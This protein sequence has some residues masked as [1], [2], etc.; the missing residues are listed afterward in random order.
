MWQQKIVE[1]ALFTWDKWRWSIINQW[2][3]LDSDLKALK[4]EELHKKT[5]KELEILG[6]P[7]SFFFELYWVCCVSSDYNLDYFQ[8]F[9]NIVV[10]EWLGICA[11]FKPSLFVHA[12]KKIK[13]SAIKHGD[14][15]YPPYLI[16]ENDIEFAKSQVDEGWL[17]GDAYFPNEKQDALILPEKHELLI[18]LS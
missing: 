17:F 4:P 10:P 14:R 7:P 8:T 3:Q 1:R 5:K 9:D 11:N 2:S 18:K 6:F 12:F 13:Y 16:N 15:L